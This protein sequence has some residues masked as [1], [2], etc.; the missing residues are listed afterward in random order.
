[1]DLDGSSTESVIEGQAPRDGALPAYRAL[2]WV[3]AALTAI[4]LALDIASRAATNTDVRDGAQ[5]ITWAAVVAALIGLILGFM[6]NAGDGSTLVR[7]VWPIIVAVLVLAVSFWMRSYYADD[8]VGSPIRVIILSAVAFL[9][10][11]A[12][13][14]MNGQQRS[15]TPPATG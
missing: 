2:T 14:V 12:Q 1:M 15:V 11:L 5:W 10:L 9:L 7:R 3:A 13:S 4:A 8:A 6:I